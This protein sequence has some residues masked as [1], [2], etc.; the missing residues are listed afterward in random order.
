MRPRLLFAYAASED[1]PQL[2]ESQ[3]PSK[4]SGFKPFKAAYLPANVP[5]FPFHKAAVML[6]SRLPMDFTQAVGAMV[7]GSI[8]TVTEPDTK[9]SVALVQ[10]VDL[11]GNYAEWRPEVQLG[12]AVGDKRGALCGA[13]Q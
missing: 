6:K 12:A 2:T 5:F 4:I 13:A 7:P 3:L 10:R 1:S 8:T 11:T 9:F